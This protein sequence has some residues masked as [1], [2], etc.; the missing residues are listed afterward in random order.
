[1]IDYDSVGAEYCIVCALYSMCVMCVVCVCRCL[2]MND[3]MCCPLDIKCV[4]V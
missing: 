4:L 1:M 2:Y 3:G